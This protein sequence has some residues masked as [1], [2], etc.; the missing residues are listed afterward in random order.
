M[1]VLRF[2]KAYLKITRNYRSID[3]LSKTFGFFPKTLIEVS[4]PLTVVIPKSLATKF[5]SK[6]DNTATPEKLGEPLIILAPS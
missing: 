3:F 5:I 4:F 1:K 2:D 6:K